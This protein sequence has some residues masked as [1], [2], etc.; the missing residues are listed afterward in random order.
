LESDDE[1]LH[2][3]WNDKTN[4]I[5]GL[6]LFHKGESKN[7][8]IEIPRAMELYKVK[9]DAASAGISGTDLVANSIS[10]KTA[11][12]KITATNFIAKEV[13][14]DAVSGGFQAEKIL[15]EKAVLHT[16]SGDSTAKGITADELR[17]DSVVGAIDLDGNLLAA[18]VSSILGNVTVHSGILPK[19]SAIS[20]ISGKLLLTLPENDGF[21]LEKTTVS[22]NFVSTT[23]PLETK[24]KE[25]YYKDQKSKN[26]VKLSTTSGAMK[27][28]K[29]TAAEKPL[30]YGGWLQEQ[31]AAKAPTEN[32]E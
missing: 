21:V 10:L 2:I 13:K 14:L 28:E 8:V 6:S 29:S 23:L 4:W 30:T 32:Q 27:L 20:T 7:L 26:T 25:T 5:F 17:A 19:K 3:R 15:C 1:T 9:V 16:V 12:G 18:D 24:G 11:S 22:G 31:L